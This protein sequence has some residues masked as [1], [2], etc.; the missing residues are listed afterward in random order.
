MRPTNTVV[1]PVYGNGWMT[2]PGGTSR[3]VPAS[4]EIDAAP[5]DAPAGIIKTTDHEFEGAIAVL[6]PRHDPPSGFYNIEVKRGT[7]L[8]AVGY[9]Q[10]T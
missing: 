3:N 9:A 5:T 2:Y 1:K 6:T 7:T 10:F 8:L 4:F